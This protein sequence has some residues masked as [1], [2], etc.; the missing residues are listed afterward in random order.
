MQTH[1]VIKIIRNYSKKNAQI[2]L[3]CDVVVIF[4]YKILQSFKFLLFKYKKGIE[5]NIFCHEHEYYFTIY[6]FTKINVYV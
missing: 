6:V 1:I 3:A 5:I 4:I 2:T